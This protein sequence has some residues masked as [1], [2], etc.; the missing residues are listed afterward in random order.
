MPLNAVRTQ[1]FPPK[2]WMR[3]GCFVFIGIA[4]RAQGGNSNRQRVS[5]RRALFIIVYASC[6]FEC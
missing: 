5:T 1:R 6:A 4:V 3:L 2:T